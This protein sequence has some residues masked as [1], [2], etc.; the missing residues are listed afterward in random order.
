[1]STPPSGPATPSPTTATIP[2][3]VVGEAELAA[4]RAA[5]TGHALLNLLTTSGGRMLVNWVIGVGKSTA[6]DAVADAAVHSGRYDLVVQ[7]LP[8]RAVLA[9]RA[10]A[11]TPPAD[12]KVVHLRPR[13]RERCGDRDPDWRHFEQSGLGLLGRESLCRSCPRLPGCFWPAQYGRALR[14]AR[15]ILATQA[16]LARA[17]HF[18]TQLARAAGAGRVLTL[19]DEDTAAAVPA[20]RRLGAADMVR[21]VGVLGAVAAVPRSNALGR[22]AHVVRL[23]AAAPTADLRAPAWRLPPL[24]PEDRLAVQAAGWHQFGREYRDLTGDVEAFAHSPL[25]SRERAPDGEVRFAAPPGVGGDVVLFSGTASLEFVRYRLGLDLPAPF[26]GVRFRH[27]QTRWYN[28]A[29][30]LGMWRYWLRNSPQILDFFAGLIARRLAEGKRV[31]TVIKK[32]FAVAAARGLEERLAA[33]GRPGV[34]VPTGDWD[35][36]NLA[37]P[38]VVPC[39][40]YGTIGVNRFELFDACYC[41][42]GFYV[43]K[44]ALD[45]VLQ[46]LAGAD[47]HIELR[48]S[49]EGE[50]RR[51]QVRAVRPD[52]R[53]VDV[54]RLAPLALTRQET[55]VVLQA[56]GRVRPYTRHREVI[57]FQCAGHPHHPYDREFGA[58]AEARAFFSLPS[59]RHAAAAGRGEAVRTLKAAGLSQRV[60][61]ERLGLGLAT[62]K[63][64]WHPPPGDHESSGNS[65]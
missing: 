23:L 40:T 13:P 43:T 57:T 30:R 8:T 39:I 60:V 48:V 19:L 14:G 1:M 52:D 54:A 15:G 44:D 45:A 24:P 53:F 46:D 50:P 6:L 22:W 37:D 47:G 20:R 51:R 25:E 4:F 29:S 28:L 33:L 59:A 35:R 36:V 61:A 31:L 9:E 41:L 27:P 21:Y 12:F 11:R 3:V 63:R 26:A 17:P 5:W 65:S 16:H 42:S 64:H 34:R 7:L 32:C 49:T 38:G 10:W 58:L 56:V 62:V 2:A 18:V 55:D